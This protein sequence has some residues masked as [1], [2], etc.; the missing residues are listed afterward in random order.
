M[1]LKLNNAKVIF[2]DGSTLDTNI[3]RIILY[4]GT[5]NH[6]YIVEHISSGGCS[7][8]TSSSDQRLKKI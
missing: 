7:D 1:K 6:E 5:N 4:R 2:D 8:G 3:G